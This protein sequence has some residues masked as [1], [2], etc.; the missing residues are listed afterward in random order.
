MQ[1]AAIFCAGSGPAQFPASLWV[2]LGYSRAPANSNLD[3]TPVI[4]LSFLK[5]WGNHSSWVLDF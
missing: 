3:P 5:G 1:R 4:S 2:N